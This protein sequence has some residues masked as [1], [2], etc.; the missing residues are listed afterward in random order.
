[1]QCFRQRWRAHWGCMRVE[2]QPCLAQ[3]VMEEVET[4]I[5]VDGVVLSREV[6]GR[7]VTAV[8]GTGGPGSKEVDGMTG[9]EAGEEVGVFLGVT[10]RKYLHFWPS[11]RTRSQDANERPA[12]ISKKKLG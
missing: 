4:G 3:V 12:F 10:H 7:I 5:R 8:E 9:E 6:S 2:M 1:M 11:S